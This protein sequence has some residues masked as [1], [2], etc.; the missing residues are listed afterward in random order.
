MALDHHLGL[1]N[2]VLGK[3]INFTKIGQ[4]NQQ[5]VISCE[6]VSI[7]SAIFHSLLRICWKMC[8]P[9]SRLMSSAT[10]E[11]S[12]KDP[13]KIILILM[14]R[15]FQDHSKIMSR[16][17]GISLKE[18]GNI[19]LVTIDVLS[20]YCV[21]AELTPL[22]LLDRIVQQISDNLKDSTKT[23]ILFDDISCLL[24]IGIPFEYVYP[25]VHRV[26][27]LSMTSNSC[28][29]MHTFFDYDEDD[30]ESNQLC[31]YISKGATFWLECSKLRTGFSEKIDGS[32]KIHDFSTGIYKRE[33][34]RFGKTLRGIRM[35]LHKQ[36]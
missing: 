20:D 10:N 19:R 8:S 24:Q 18:S 26:R 5:I 11:N 4:E 3:V 17:F 7:S 21:L 6:D 13:V 29:I 14:N 16:N 15:S 33:S 30:I 34:Y 36:E 35:E 31:E 28:L 27:C 32:L 25:F 22:K 23:I 9:S 1:E 2:E 12:G